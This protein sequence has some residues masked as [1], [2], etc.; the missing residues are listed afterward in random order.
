[1]QPGL[2]HDEKQQE[3]EE[4]T[5]QQR[6]QDGGFPTGPFGQVLFHGNFFAPR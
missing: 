5:G 6:E 3:E 4:D 2:T 1:M